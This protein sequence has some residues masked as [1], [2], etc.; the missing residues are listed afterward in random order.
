MA[1]ATDAVSLPPEVA[2]RGEPKL[3]V[4][5]A[6]GKISGLRLFLVA[7]GFVSFLACLVMAI[8][9]FVN[10]IKPFGK[11]APP[12]G[13]SFIAAGILA[14]LGLLMAY[15]AYHYAFGRFG[16]GSY[17]FFDDALVVL[18]HDNTARVIPWERVQPE[19]KSSSLNPRHAFPVE[20]EDDLTFDVLAVDHD[21]LAAAITR[22]A[23]L[24][25]WSG[26]IDLARLSTE[27][28]A[29]AFLVH[30]PSDT[31]LYRVSLLFGKLLFA[32]VG[33]GCAQGTRGF[34]ARAVHTQGGLA[35]G[36]AVWMQMKQIEKIQREL[37][38]LEGLDE[39][40]LIDAAAGL[41]GSRLVEVSEMT[42]VRFT[43][44]GVWDGL[45]TGVKIVAV[46]RFTH[47]EW[48][49]KKLYLESLTQV[50]DA[51]RILQDVLGQDFRAEAMQVARG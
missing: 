24:V 18:A 25:R 49:E 41:T 21:V 46:L 5:L 17:H 34:P 3:V 37:D 20:G 2:A 33:N 40:R 8:P 11:N 38:K 4:N 51:A 15:A 43:K 6:D 47:D 45:S 27:R 12:P 13:V 14:T 31:G 32:R 7:G 19:K 26:V 22:Q 28:P 10:G 44:P 35:G 48:G 23:T 50:G 1:T 9:L 42:H 30:D 16:G 39:R 29:P 36:M